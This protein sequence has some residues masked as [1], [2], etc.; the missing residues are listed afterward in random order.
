MLDAREEAY[1]NKITLDSEDEV[2]EIETR[3]TYHRSAAKRGSI[4]SSYILS[5]RTY[6][7]DLY[8]YAPTKPDMKGEFEFYTDWEYVSPD[9]TSDPSYYKLIIPEDSVTSALYY[10]INNEE[11]AQVNN[12]Y[13][14]HQ[15]DDKYMTFMHKF[16][17]NCV[18]FFWPKYRCADRTKGIFQ[19]ERYDIRERC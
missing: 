15:S 10:D 9:D 16:R 18:Y 1:H 6:D 14:T 13:Y 17:R 2:E 3:Y 12:E 11:L 4:T 19:S 8:V 5:G 7:S